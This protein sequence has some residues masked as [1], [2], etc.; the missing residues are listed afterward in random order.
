MIKKVKTDF[1]HIDE[2]G[3]LVQ[4]VHEGFNQVNVLDTRGGVERGGHFHKIARER[5]YIVKGTVEVT[6]KKDGEEGK[7][8]FSKGDFFEIAPFTVHSMFFPED[9]LMVA[10]YDVPV[11]QSDGS[12]D[13]YPAEDSK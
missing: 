4:L 13:I 5:F 1:S 10:M 2:R 7:H 12:K 9:C 3:S 8:V 11:E 6:A